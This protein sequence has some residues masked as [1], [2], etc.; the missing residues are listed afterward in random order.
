MLAPTRSK[1]KV[2]RSI[3]PP[4]QPGDQ[5]SRI[6]F[7][8]RYDA[9]P[10]LKKAE[11]IEGVVH[12]PPPVSD[13]SHSQPHFD[14]ITWLGAYRT[15]TAG[16]FGGDNGSLRLDL[17]NMPQPDAYLR[18]DESNGGQSRKDADGYVA[19]APE[20]IAEVA[21]TSASYDLHVKLHVYRRNG[22]R[23]YIVWR[24]IDRQID[25]FLLHQGQYLPL[26][27]SKSGIYQSRVFPGLWLDPKALINGDMVKVNAVLKK[28]IATPKHRA[29]VAQLKRRAKNK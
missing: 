20:L 18:I 11:L 1:P 6:E 22:V 25:Y 8:R 14:L 13:G 9:T 12:M 26:S 23:E 2:V 16:I 19:G 27:P 15:A 28:G 5:L 3:V 4:L 21:A 7:E 29:F 10:H 17:D 24:V